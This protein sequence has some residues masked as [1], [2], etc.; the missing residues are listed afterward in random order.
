MAQYRVLI[1]NQEWKVVG[2]VDQWISLDI[3]LKYNEVS[4]WTLKL[5]VLSKSAQLFYELLS[6]PQN[7]GIPGVYIE[8]NG[9]FLLSGSVVD[10]EESV[11]AD[12]EV[13]T[14][15]GDCDLRWVAKRL[16][17]PHP[18]Y[19]ASPYMNSSLYGEGGTPYHQDG[20]PNEGVKQDQYA[21]SHIYAFVAD[22]VGQNQGKA[23]RKL[24]F[25]HCVDRKNGYLIPSDECTIARGENLLLLGIAPSGAYWDQ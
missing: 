17:L 7:G 22:N 21:S 11:Q 20:F 4:K 3:E 16:A 14:L 19:M 18:K 1:R 13:L 9:M 2:Q 25:L 24:P 12:G 23:D 10:V 8:R 15:Y 5:D 6:N